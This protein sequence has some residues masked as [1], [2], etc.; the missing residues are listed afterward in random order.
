M[1]RSREPSVISKAQIGERYGVS[2]AGVCQILNLLELDESMQ[3]YLLSIED[4]KEHNYFTERK[5][6]SIAILKY[7]EEQIRGFRELVYDMRFELN[8]EID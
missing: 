7:R 8:V 1:L 5:L 6:R 2:R 4:V 3:K